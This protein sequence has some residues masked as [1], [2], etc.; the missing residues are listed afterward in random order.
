MSKDRERDQTERVETEKQ[1]SREGNQRD[2]RVRN[3]CSGERKPWAQSDA[4]MIER[5]IRETAQGVGKNTQGRGYRTRATKEWR[6]TSQRFEM[7]Y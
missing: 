6:D 2:F 5:G 7:N 3:T 4:G 1:K